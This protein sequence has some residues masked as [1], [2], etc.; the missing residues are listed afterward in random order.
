MYLAQTLVGIA[1][2]SRFIWSQ[3]TDIIDEI[4]WHNDGHRLHLQ[5]NRN[6]LVVSSVTCPGGDDRQCAIGKTDCIVQHFVDIYGLEC[7]VGICDATS[8]MTVAWSAVGDMEDLDLCQVWIIPIDDEA[9]SA[10]LITQS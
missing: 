7:N 8:E 6:E 10:W 1:P 2:V 9:F 3:M 4:V 5:I